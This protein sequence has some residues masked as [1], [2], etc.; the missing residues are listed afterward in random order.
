ME[1]TLLNLSDRIKESIKESGLKASGKKSELKE[2]LMQ[3]MEGCD[4]VK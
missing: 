1:R 3:S 2:R 4:S